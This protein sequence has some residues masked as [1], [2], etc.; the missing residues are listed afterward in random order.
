M[1][2]KKEISLIANKS[3]FDKVINKAVINNVKNIM[4]KDY[5][6][7]LAKGSIKNISFKEFVQKTIFLMTTNAIIEN[8]LKVTED[9][10]LSIC[11]QYVIFFNEKFPDLEDMLKTIE[12][13]KHWFTDSELTLS[14]LTYKLLVSIANNEFSAQLLLKFACKGLLEE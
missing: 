3:Q 8:Q 13:R 4:K 7:F 5:D 12:S 9:M 6:S 2:N 14:Q 11:M 10:I 1:K